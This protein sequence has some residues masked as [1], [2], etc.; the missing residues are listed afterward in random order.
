MIKDFLNNKFKDV[1][2]EGI[3]LH[4][5]ENYVVKT[6]AKEPFL[7]D[8]LSMILIQSGKFK[9]KVEERVQDLAAFDLLVI[10]QNS[11]CSV[12]EVQDKLQLFLVCFSPQFASQKHESKLLVDFIDFFNSRILK[13]IT[14]EEKDFLVLSMTSKLFYFG[15]EDA[16]TKNNDLGYR[17]RQITFYLLLFVLRSV[18]TKHSSEYTLAF[19]RKEELTARFFNLLWVH[20]K[21][22]HSV[23]FY[24]DTLF[25]TSGYLNKS[26]LEIIGKTVKTLINETIIIE[27][28]NLLEDPRR[29]ITQIAG[30]LGFSTGFIFSTFFKKQT[31]ISPSQYRSNISEKHKNI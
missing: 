1:S 10:P 18:Y 19:K 24:A 2:Q 12:M 17:F 20:Y 26:V 14:I 31:S 27:A 29:S 3:E 16:K 11:F 13:K 8:N 30:E 15:N 28:K 21:K 4:F 6:S 7:V 25:I 23:Q 22:Q 5:I 9:I